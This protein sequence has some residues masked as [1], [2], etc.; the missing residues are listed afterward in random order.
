MPDLNPIE[1]LW[2]VVKDKLFNEIPPEDH[3]ELQD[4]I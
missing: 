4:R 3:K 2:N 1:I